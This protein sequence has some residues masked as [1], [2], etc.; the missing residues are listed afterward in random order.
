MLNIAY[1]TTIEDYH[2]TTKK[3]N[4]NNQETTKLTLDKSNKVCYTIYINH[5]SD[6]PL[7]EIKIIG[8]YVVLHY[9]RAAG[10]PLSTYYFRCLFEVD[11]ENRKL[12]DIIK[13][14]YF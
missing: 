9:E 4:I 12:D 6:E 14:F 1:G 5:V 11:K 10:E 7:E 2:T 13:M 8:D 3:L